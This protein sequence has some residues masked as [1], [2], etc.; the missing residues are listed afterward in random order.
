[1][2]IEF[3]C[4]SCNQLLRVPD[5]SAGKNAKCPKCSTIVQIP[6]SGAPPLPSSNWAPQPPAQ[7]PKPNPFSETASANPYATPTAASFQ[8]F[9]QRRPGAKVMAPAIALLIVGL[10]G[11]AVSLFNVGFAFVRQPQVDPNAPEFIQAM[12]RGVTGPVAAAIQGMFVLVNLIIIG[13][14]LQMLRFRSWGL[15]L[16][17]SILAM[18]N[19]GSCCCGLGLPVGI[20]S[21]V[22]LASSDVKAAF[23]AAAVPAVR[24]RPFG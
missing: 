17:A 9:E 23:L 13:G 22:V 8:P 1:M 16:A 14:A 6:A 7:A 20:W 2:A 24:D 3:S 4:P 11:V 15:A 18:V 12:Q 21:L 10:L 5:E 19:F